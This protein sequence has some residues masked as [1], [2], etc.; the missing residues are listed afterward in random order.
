MWR[1]PRGLGT[2]CWSPRAGEALAV[3]E[4]VCGKCDLPAA[5]EG[6]H[7]VAAAAG[8]QHTVLITS[9]GRALACG[10]NKYGQCN[11]A[12]APQGERYVA[13]AASWWFTVLV[14]SG[15]RMLGRGKNPARDDM[16]KLLAGE[17][18]AF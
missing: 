8:E 1:L 18:V 4:R 5:P 15:G 2:Q 12:A 3:G 11:L 7:F 14:T 10:H 13:A 6:E 17:V 9:G 16:P